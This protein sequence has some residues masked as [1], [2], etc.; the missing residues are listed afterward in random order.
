MSRQQEQEQQEQEQQEQEQQEKIMNK[1]K[2]DILNMHKKIKMYRGGAYAPPLPPSVKGGVIGEL[3]SRGAYAPPLPP[4]VKG[5]VIGERSSPTST[6]Y[7]NHTK[8]RE[9]YRTI[10]ET[11]YNT[12]NNQATNDGK[13]RGKW[14]A[15]V[16]YQLMAHTR[17]IVHGY[18]E[19][20]LAYMQLFEWAR[21][22]VS[23]AKHALELFVNSNNGSSNIGSWK[24]VKSFF[25]YMRRV[26]NVRDDRDMQAYVEMTDFMVGMVNAR[27][28]ADVLA[29]Y[30]DDNENENDDDHD[31]DPTNSKCESVSLVSKWIPRENK[32]KKYGNL[33]ERLACDYYKMWLPKD[34]SNNTSYD[35][36]VL[37]C[38]IH[39]RKLISFFNRYL[40]TPQIKMCEQNWANI[41]FDR[42]GR[43]TQKLQNAAF[44]NLN[45]DK[46]TNQASQTNQNKDRETCADKY[47]TW[48]CNMLNYKRG[49]S[50]NL[51]H[52]VTDIQYGLYYL[53][54]DKNA[55]W[56]AYLT[57]LETANTTNL[58]YMI[59][60]LT[61]T[62][63]RTVGLALAVAE[64]SV[65]GKKLITTTMTD[66]KTR[67]NL[68]LYNLEDSF[69]KNVK[70]L[71]PYNSDNKDNNNDKDKLDIYLSL[72]AVL[73]TMID[74]GI[75]PKQFK[76]YPQLTVVIF[77]DRETDVS[78]GEC[79]TCDCMCKFNSAYNEA[80][81]VYA[82]FG[83][84][85]PKILLWAL[86]SES[87]SELD[88]EHQLQYYSS[89]NILSRRVGCGESDIV[90]FLGIA[91]TKDTNHQTQI[92]TQ[93][94]H[95]EQKCD[96]YAWIEEWNSLVNQLYNS[97]S[98]ERHINFGRYFWKCM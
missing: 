79:E 82:E 47:K 58:K 92:Q 94:H 72:I 42:V 64:K 60:V 20:D 65:I 91:D 78:I 52:H 21:V 35:K 6:N 12:I 4:S 49:I 57:Q 62:S 98:N 13:R 76:E 32:S 27:L 71:R 86:K 36:A 88:S 40:D 26:I 43:R 54:S 85:A 3:R 75:T 84:A 45:V 69:V 95:S 66:C 22:D 33:Y 10:L 81:R 50:S 63:F 89:G 7:L 19:R 59:P 39:Y 29:F 74:S 9:E 5:G 93:N 53:E 46:Q 28:A 16:L 56:R 97:N 2:T 67:N 24:D 77:A 8:V 51:V 15:E 61:G 38:K 23:L 30:S 34:K 55:E 90:R 1:L 96:E 80:V 48:K 83:Y 68:E 18:G 44:L 31:H 11:A 17:D 25:A 70:K 37:K 87:E 41:D 73:Q 14:H